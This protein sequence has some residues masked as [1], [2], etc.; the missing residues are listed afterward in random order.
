MNGMWQ[1]WQQRYS[2]DL[3]QQIVDQAKKIEPQ[4]AIIGFSG[5]NIDTNVRRSKVRWINRDNKELG[6][7]YEEI[8]NL[9]HIANHN[10]FGADIRFLNELQFTEYNAEDQ[11][12]YN[13]HN[14]VNWD[15][16][17]QVHRKLSFVCQLTDP[18]E[19]EGGEFE[20]QPLYLGAPD[21]KQLKTQGTAIIF[22]SLVMHKVNPVTKGT[23]HSLVAWIEGPK[24]R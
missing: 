5:S 21:P 22:P 13:W 2:K 4:D 15:D 18:E 20:M 9:F 1:L 12:Y 10:A 17:R 3:C 11:G 19:Y 24:W 8:T 16:G 6:W 7:L 23:R 14:D